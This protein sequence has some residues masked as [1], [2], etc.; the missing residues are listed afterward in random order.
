MTQARRDI[1]R[2]LRILNYA[3]AVGNISQACRHFGISRQIF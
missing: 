2:K 1:S 3:K